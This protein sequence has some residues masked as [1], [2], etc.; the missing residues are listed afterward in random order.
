MNRKQ[1]EEKL[2]KLSQDYKFSI[3]ESNKDFLVIKSQT[4]TVKISKQTIEEH[5]KSKLPITFKDFHSVQHFD[6]KFKDQVKL[7]RQLK[8]EHK[9]EVIFADNGDFVIKSEAY[10]IKIE[11]GYWVNMFKEE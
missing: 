4:C 11:Y 5:N 8:K 10:E 6:S 7:R 9:F 1:K 2:I 3:G